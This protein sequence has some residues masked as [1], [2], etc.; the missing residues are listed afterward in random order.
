MVIKLDDLTELFI[1][2]LVTTEA[3]FFSVFGALDSEKNPE[4]VKELE[5]NFNEIFPTSP[6]KRFLVT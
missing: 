3:I 1:V 4:N 2:L 6:Q 5:S